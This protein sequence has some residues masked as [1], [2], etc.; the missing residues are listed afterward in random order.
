MPD[1]RVRPLDTWPRDRRP[2]HERSRFDSPWAATVDLLGREL[3]HLAARNAVILVD[4]T[5]DDIRIDGT[6]PKANA[7]VGYP[8]VVVAFDSTH[9]PLKYVADTF[10]HWQDNVRAIALGLEA[11]RKVDRYGIT[12]RGEQYTGWAQLPSGIETPA[13]RMTVDDA[14]RFLAEHGGPWT[15]SGPT[16]WMLEDFIA[17]AR[18]ED[19]RVQL[20]RI[21]AK[22]LHPDAPTGDTALFQRLQAAKALLDDR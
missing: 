8:G 4:C 22:K 7:R 19:L 1:I 13:A 15:E 9:G 2:R 5:P 6:M 3:R 14:W 17:G 12:S 21:A 20:Y 18:R 16:E 10:D 11:L